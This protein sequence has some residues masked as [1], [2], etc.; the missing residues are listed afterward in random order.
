[1]LQEPEASKLVTQ[2][3]ENKQIFKDEIMEKRE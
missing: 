1:M 3:K 2:K